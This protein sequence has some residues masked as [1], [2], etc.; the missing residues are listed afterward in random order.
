MMKIYVERIFTQAYAYVCHTH[1]DL[2]IFE[3]VRILSSSSS[4]V[5]LAHLSPLRLFNI[6][7]SL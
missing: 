5:F 6:V 7:V 3:H 2:L 1:D 4:S